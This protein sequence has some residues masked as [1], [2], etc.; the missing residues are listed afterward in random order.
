VRLPELKKLGVTTLWLMPIHPVGIKKSFGSPYCVRDFKGINPQLGTAEDL[1]EL[2]R[3]THAAGMKLIMDLVADH[4]AWDN[5]LIEEHPD[6]YVHNA[7]GEIIWPKG[8]QW[9]D[10]A[11]LDYSNPGIRN[12]MIGVMKY[13]L[14]EFDV[15]G[16]RCDAASMIPVDF[17][18]RARKEVERTKPGVM[19]LAEAYDPKLMADAFDVDYSWALL[20]KLDEVMTKGN[21]ASQIQEVCEREVR[22]FPSR[23]VPMRI[24]DDHDTKRATLNYGQVGS[25]AA[26]VLVMT[27]SGAPLLYNG[28]EVGDEGATPIQW[29]GPKQTELYN[30]YKSLLDLHKDNPALLNGETHWLKNS[31]PAQVL[32]YLRTSKTD[33][34]LIVVNLSNKPANGVQI[35]GASASGWTNVTPALE[36][37]S[38][39]PME[40][41][42]RP[43]E[44]R[45][46]ERHS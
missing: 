14:T 1:H 34:F 5:P 25:L 32:S 41:T 24:S 2:I 18:E 6:Y 43:F 10:V 37:I 3:A 19:M 40:G 23:T 29:D 30:F 22:D 45:V 27:Q 21:P 11:G 9:K 12:Y 26:S 42:Y 20:N 39:G 44:F 38:N 33:Q 15:D 28:M 17:W 13:W 16:F 35:D 4:T 8:T 31:D 7:Q 46:F 36:A